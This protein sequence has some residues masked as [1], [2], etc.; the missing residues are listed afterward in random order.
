MAEF[1]IIIRETNEKEFSSELEKKRKKKKAEIHIE[2]C[3]VFQ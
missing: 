1:K 2:F 3:I